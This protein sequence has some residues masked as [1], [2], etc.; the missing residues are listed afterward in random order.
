MWICQYLVVHFVIDWYSVSLRSLSFPVLDVSSATVSS[1]FILGAVPSTFLSI[2]SGFVFVAHQSRGDNHIIAYHNLTYRIVSHRSIS[3]RRCPYQFMS[4]QSTGGRTVQELYLDTSTESIFKSTTHRRTTVGFSGHRLTR[5]QEKNDTKFVF[6][7]F[8]LPSFRI[9]YVLPFS[10]VFCFRFFEFSCLFGHSP[11]I[12]HAS[13]MYHTKNSLRSPVLA[14][15]WLFLY[16]ARK[17]NPEARRRERRRVMG[18]GARG[19]S[20]W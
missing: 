4:N 19:F 8:F 10:P 16:I 20:G 7:A 15:T 6:G 2:E 5:E 9:F 14:A 12:N 1:S 3:Y 11:K 13:R 18:S 17:T